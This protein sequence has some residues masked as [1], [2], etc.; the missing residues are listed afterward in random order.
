M[1]GRFRSHSGQVRRVC[2]AEARA[3]RFATAEKF[4]RSHFSPSP[5][6]ALAFEKVMREKPLSQEMVEVVEGKVEVPEY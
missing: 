1:E 6:G 3:S 5:A 2:P 4:T